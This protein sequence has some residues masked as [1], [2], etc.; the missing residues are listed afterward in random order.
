VPSPGEAIKVKA[1]SSTE[2][3]RECT[4]GSW[5]GHKGTATLQNGSEINVAR[6]PSGEFVEITM[7][8]RPSQES[9]ATQEQNSSS[10]PM[11]SST[12]MSSSAPIAAERSPVTAASD[13]EQQVAKITRERDYYKNKLSEVEE[14][15]NDVTSKASM[16]YSRAYEAATA[17]AETKVSAATADGE[18]K[19]KS[20]QEAYD[21]MRGNLTAQ[22]TALEATTK[23]LK[24][25]LEQTKRIL[26]K[27]VHALENT[28]AALLS[29]AQEE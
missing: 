29:A 24:E 16:E 2:S 15:L 6:L 18:K 22:I 3:P 14:Q 19:V 11:S 20:V 12:P 26:A 8:G 28:A 21:Q 17:E 10:A 4:L 5:S 7:I 25:N 1:R 27:K 9:D 23:A 13:M